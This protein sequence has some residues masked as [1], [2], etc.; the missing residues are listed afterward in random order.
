MAKEISNILHPTEY[1]VARR[2]EEKRLDIPLHGPARC[3]SHGFPIFGGGL[4]IA[5]P[6]LLYQL[7]LHVARNQQP[8]MAGKFMDV[9]MYAE[10]S[11]ARVSPCPRIGQ[12]SIAIRLS[13]SP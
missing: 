5:H 8:L 3:H 9:H 7:S 13:S 6:F 4:L 2:K 12:D 10:G 11:E 1:T